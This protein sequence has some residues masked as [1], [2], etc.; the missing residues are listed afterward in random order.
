MQSIH[1]RI[2][3]ELKT[4]DIDDLEPLQGELKKLSDKNFNKLRK[5]LIEKGFKLVLHVW[6]N[7]GVNYL[8]DGHQRVY[9]LQQLRKQG[10]E[11]PPIPCAL[12][13][14]RTYS[15]AKE[16]V[17]MAISQYGKVDEKGFD[18]FIDGEDFDLDAFDIP[19]LPDY[20]FPSLETQPDYA[21]IDEAEDSVIDDM[22]KELRKAIQI[23]FTIEDYGIATDLVKKANNQKLDV[24]KTLIECLSEK[25]L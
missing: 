12:V 21:I 8:I 11:V 19:N 25:V 18:D 20:D 10:Y 23:E 22:K 6:Q 3:S 7:G 14:A 17:L 16:T 24:G 13:Q 5:S 2:D 9:V 15:E 4:F 1:L